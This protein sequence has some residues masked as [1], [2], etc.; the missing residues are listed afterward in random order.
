MAG[1]PEALTR[2]KS[3]AR[4]QTLTWAGVGAPADRV[5][6]VKL[7]NQATSK[8]F[9]EE[10]C[11]RPRPCRLWCLR[12]KGPARAATIAPQEA[13]TDSRAARVVNGAEALTVGLTAQGCTALSTHIRKREAVPTIIYN[14]TFSNLVT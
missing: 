4:T 5:T 2:G 13:T 3:T 14:N 11:T 1:A 9:S 8:T 7:W 6:G 10:P 12:G